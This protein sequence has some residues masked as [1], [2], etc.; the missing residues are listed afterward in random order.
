MPLRVVSKRG[1]EM[2][3]WRHGVDPYRLNVHAVGGWTWVN[4]G[5]ATATQGSDRSILLTAPAGAGE[6]W[7][8]LTRTAPAVP[9]S[10]I[11]CF[12]LMLLPEGSQEPSVAVGFR[13]SGTQELELWRIYIDHTT[14]FVRATDVSRWDNATTFNASYTGAYPASEIHPAYTNIW[15][16]IRDDN[17]FRYYFTSPDGIDWQ[18]WTLDARTTFLTADQLCFGANADSAN[19]AAIIKLRHFHTQTEA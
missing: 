1:R 15:M 11:W 9:Y 17:V 5:G 13:Q 6:N 19:N 12:S 8:L 2:R 18:L 16:K 4:Q 10:A 3:T 7:R 14:F